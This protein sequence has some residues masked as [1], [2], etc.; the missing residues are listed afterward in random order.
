M[1]VPSRVSRLL[2]LPVSE[3]LAAEVKP[4]GCYAPAGTLLWLGKGSILHPVLLCVAG[5]LHLWGCGMLP[6]PVGSPEA[7]RSSSF[8]ALLWYDPQAR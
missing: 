3:T 4:Q 7:T 5:N 8:S 2:L 1:E 6:L